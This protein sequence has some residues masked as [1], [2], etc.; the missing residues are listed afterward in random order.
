MAAG[1]KDTLPFFRQRCCKYAYELLT[2]SPE[3]E[4]GLLTILVSQLVEAASKKDAST[5]AYFLQQL[6]LEHPPMKKVLAQYVGDALS[7]RLSVTTV[8][9]EEMGTLYRPVLFLTSFKYS[10]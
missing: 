6:L 10:K 7:K 5:A 2:H 3:Q 1:C 9:S 8:D 4:K